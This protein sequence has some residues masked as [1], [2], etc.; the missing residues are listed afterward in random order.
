M[1]CGGYNHHVKPYV[2]F[3]AALLLAGCSKNIQNSEAVRSA[4]IEYLNSRAPQTGLDVNAMQVDIAS[5]TFEKDTARVTVSIT[6]KNTQGGGMQMSYNLDRKGDKWVVRPGG[7]PHG[8]VAP[9]PN[10]GAAP[11][12]QKLPPGHPPI[13]KQ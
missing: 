13:G 9:P 11:S 10:P 8:M 12:G 2:A 7:T 1:R 3:F 4:V 6:P 5:T